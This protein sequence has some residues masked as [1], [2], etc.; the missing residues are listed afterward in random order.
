M[1]F[2]FTATMRF[3]KDADIFGFSWDQ[4]VRWS[5]LSHL[6]EVVS[7]DHILNKVV[8]I[9][10][11]ENPDDWNYIFSADEMSTGLFTSLDFV[12]SRLK[13]GV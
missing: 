12:L 9:P 8:V 10:D 3:D 5:G 2:L 13:A 1:E 7:L 11:Y 4:Y 6:T